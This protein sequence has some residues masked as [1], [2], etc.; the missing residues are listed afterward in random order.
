VSKFKKLKNVKNRNKR[1]STVAN[2][3]EDILQRQEDVTEDFGD[4]NLHSNDD[5]KLRLVRTG[6]HPDLVFFDPSLSEDERREG[7]ENVCGLSLEKEED[8]W[9]LE[10]LWKAV[11]SYRPPPVPIVLSHGW[12]T[13]MDGGFIEI[14]CNFSPDELANFL[15]DNLE[16]V[17]ERRKELIDSFIPV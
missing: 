13:S 14:P 6:F 3:V 16:S 4:E 1:L 12:K 15:E 7:I 8:V 11:R 2:Q 17:R 9:L 5:M 10:N